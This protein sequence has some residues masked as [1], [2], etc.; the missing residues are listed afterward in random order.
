MGGKSRPHTHNLVIKILNQQVEKRALR[1]LSGIQNLE[2]K[3]SSQLIEESSEIILSITQQPT[4]AT[5]ITI[6]KRQSDYKKNES[7]SNVN[8]TLNTNEDYGFTRG[9]GY[10]RNRQ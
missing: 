9:A 7:S 8:T 3:Y 5:F 2:K 4:L 10:W 6:I 1:I